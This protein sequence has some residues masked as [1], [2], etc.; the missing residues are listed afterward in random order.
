M[1]RGPAQDA[2]Q[3]VTPPLVCGEDPVAEQKGAGARVIG[4]DA[5]GHVAVRVGAVRHTGELARPH[6]ERTKQ[7]GVV[8]AVDALQHA[9]QPLQPQTRID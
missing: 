2:A 5:H 1:S 9:G 7:I 6:E 3:H 8:V 4:H